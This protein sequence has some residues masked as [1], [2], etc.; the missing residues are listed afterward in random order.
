MLAILGM[1]LGMVA[2]A[3]PGDSLPQQLAQVRSFAAAQGDAVWPG[4]GA[5][6][7]GVLLIEGDRE[8]LLCRDAPPGFTADGTDAA[9]GC[10][11]YVRP[12][13]GMPDS[14][15]AAMPL[16]GP[17]SVIV[18]GTPASTGRAPGDWTRTIL[19]EHFH[20]YQSAL[21]DYYARTA[22]LDLAGGDE[23]GMW[24]L[25]YPFPYDHAATLAAYRGASLA[26]TDAVA[27]RGTPGFAAA[28]D[29]YLATRAAF[30]A[31]VSARDWRYLDFELW[32]EGVARWTELTLGAQFPDAGVRD[33]SARLLAA[34][35]AEL[36]AP[37]MPGRK[38]E[39]VYAMGAAEAMLMEACGPAW[40][41]R[42]PTV[43]G[44]GALLAEARKGCL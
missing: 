21:P 41:A 23:T 27:A 15:L 40:R 4:F 43:L 8:T 16:F 30:A 28:F 38:R 10:A 35:L 11:R 24:M 31:T 34:T 17:P 36:R 33:E 29:R 1:A 37:D 14:I 2:A 19:H 13:A 3:A 22:A 44:N 20:Q 18:M 9:T 5:A 32:Q 7:F 26:L 42:Y 39:I 12:R 6:P 25:N